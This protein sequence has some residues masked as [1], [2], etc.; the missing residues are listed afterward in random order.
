MGFLLIKILLL[1]GLAAACG[2]GAAYWWFRRHYEDVTLE[3]ARTREEWDAWRRNFEERLASRP[4]V[5]LEPVAQQL[6][7]VQ[8]A[9]GAL[10]IP[11]PPDLTPL[12]ARLEELTRRVEALRI[13][14]PPDLGATDARLT[15]IEHALFPVQ[16][17][18]DELTGAIRALRAPPSVPQAREPD[19]AP[20]K[21]P[22]R[23]GSRN[24]LTHPA[25]GQPD[26]LTQIKGLPKVLE[27]TLHEV[28]VFYFWQIAEWS[29]EDVEYVA[30]QLEDYEG[31]IEAD[32]VSQAGELASLPSAA[33]RPTEH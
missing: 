7:G 13:P 24:L 9:V 19:P 3:Y 4:A 17:R 18:L 23:E 22:V 29:P 31:R 12:H 14:E 20:P 5:N 8:A 25:H 11:A 2:A 30:S 15:A 16:T 21:P 10:E 33:P 26:D 27:H 1:L 32:W 6:A 28:G